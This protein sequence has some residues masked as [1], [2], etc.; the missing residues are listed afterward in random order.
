MNWSQIMNPGEFWGSF[1]QIKFT[2]TK[3]ERTD[4]GLFQLQ[5]RRVHRRDSSKQKI[6][7]ISFPVRHFRLLISPSAK[8]FIIA[9]TER[10]KFSLKI[11][12]V[13]PWKWIFFSPK[14]K[15]RPQLSVGT[16]SPD[17]PTRTQY[18]SFDKPPTY[19]HSRPESD[20]WAPSNETWLKLN[21]FIFIYLIAIQPVKWHQTESFRQVDEISSRWLPVVLWLGSRVVFFH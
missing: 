12:H 15:T 3:V 20:G 2:R 5:V 13:D 21:T 10:E 7:K 9:S 1:T 11:T 16:S 19:F 17:M 18:K 14:I 8:L 4:Q 6:K